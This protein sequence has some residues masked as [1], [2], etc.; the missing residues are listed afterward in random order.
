[1]AWGPFESFIKGSPVTRPAFILPSTLLV[2]EDGA[3]IANTAPVISCA[4]S[5]DLG[6]ALPGL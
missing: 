4:Q 5:G 2:S 3:V 6:Y 1:M